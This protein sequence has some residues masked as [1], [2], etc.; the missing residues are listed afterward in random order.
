[1][2]P[3]YLKETLGTSASNNLSGSSADGI[4]DALYGL[5][6]NDTLTGAGYAF[7]T[8]LV[9]GSG[10]DTYKA[11]SNAGIAILENGNSQGDIIIA[12]G[13]GIDN[14][15]SYVLEINGRHLLFGDS[16]SGQLVMIADWQKSE[17][18]V[19]K[20]ELQ[21]T[22]LDYNYVASNFRNFPNYLGNFTYEQ[23]ENLSDDSLQFPDSIESDISSIFARAKELEQNSLN[24]NPTPNELLNNLSFYMKNI[25]DFDGNDLGQHDKWKSIGAIDLQGDGDKEYVFVN[26]ANGRWSSV[27]VDPLTGRINFSNHGRGGDT[28]IVGIYEDPLVKNGIV[29]KNGPHDSQRRFQNDLLIDNLTLI[30]NSGRDYDRDGLQEIYFRVNDGTAVLHALM[31]ADGNI[32]YAN[33]QSESD[34]ATFMNGLGISSSVWG[35]WI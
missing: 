35:N 10:A 24:N 32:Q 33:Y 31:H 29:Q 18:Q 9:G 25:R 27:G 28:R 14:N 2:T 21:D 6:G 7:T 8:V 5:A 16:D 34:L 17:N 12:K 4:Y 3:S 19:E 22:T 15:N 13:I 20:I 26:S 1:M 30:E 23:L 11:E